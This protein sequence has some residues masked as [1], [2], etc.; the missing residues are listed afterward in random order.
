MAL[1]LVVSEVW[2]PTLEHLC[3][4]LLAQ[5]HDV[6]LL[7]TKKIEFKTPGILQNLQ[8]LTFFKSWSI[9]ESLRL[10]PWLVHQR[11][12]VIHLVLE[13]EKIRPAMWVLAAFAR[14]FPGCILTTSFL[15]LEKDLRGFSALSFLVKESDI[16]TGPS[17]A[18]LAQLRGVA[19]RSARQGRGLLPPVLNA[20][21]PEANTNEHSDLSYLDVLK[22]MQRP[23]ALPF[24]IEDWP[25]SQTYTETIEKLRPKSDLVFCGSW[26]HSQRKK[27]K[28]WTEWMTTFHWWVTG[29]LTDSIEVQLLSQCEALFLAGMDINTVELAYWINKA[30]KAKTALVI[31]DKQS[32]VYQHLWKNEVNCWVL[33]LQKNGSLNPK[34][35]SDWLTESS[36]DLPESLNEHILS[37]KQWLDSPFNELNRL[38]MKALAHKNKLFL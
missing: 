2:N 11:P 23:L 32:K 31:D 30:L 33:P 28:R 4:S 10:L 29:E 9:A 26:M 21:P 15:H 12:Q 34:A 16:I 18:A 19:V 1:M 5:Q 14:S 24:F 13:D 22:K 25:G 27:R 36:W 17:L 3:R 38:Y 20:T 8:T 6:R 7:T 35:F 37:Q